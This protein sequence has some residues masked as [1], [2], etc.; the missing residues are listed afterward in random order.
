[1]LSACR[2]VKCLSENRVERMR[3]ENTNYSC[4]LKTLNSD[5]V[6]HGTTCQVSL[7]YWYN[8]LS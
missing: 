4:E 3:I 5:I 8:N 7:A 6:I 1:M 2:L